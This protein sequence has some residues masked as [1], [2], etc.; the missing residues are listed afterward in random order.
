MSE[1]GAGGTV[2]TCTKWC[3]LLVNCA[4][5]WASYIAP[6]S[7][8]ESSCQPSLPPSWTTSHAEGTSNSIRLTSLQSHNFVYMGRYMNIKFEKLQSFIRIRIP[9]CLD[10]QRL[11]HGGQWLLT[12]IRGKNLEV[13]AGLWVHMLSGKG[14]EVCYQV[15]SEFNS[16]VPQRLHFSVWLRLVSKWDSRQAY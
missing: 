4:F 11:A 3:E 1:G 13:P 14:S 15:R 8:W 6:C 5:G 10:E 16:I 2:I 7:D 9:G 12:I